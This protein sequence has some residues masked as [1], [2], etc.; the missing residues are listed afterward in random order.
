[1]MKYSKRISTLEESLTIAISSLARDLKAQGKDILSFSAGEPD[2]DTPKIIK[3][4]A[5]RAINSGFTK[6]TQVAGINELL[7]A[8]SNKLKNENNLDYD[9]FYHL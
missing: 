3:D 7:V 5:M 2:F 4:E 6:Y 1:M 8:I 9:I